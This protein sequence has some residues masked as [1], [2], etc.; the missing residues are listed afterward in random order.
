[1]LIGLSADTIQF[2]IIKVFRM[3]DQAHLVDLELICIDAVFK[4]P[5]N[6]FY[7]LLKGKRLFSRSNSH[8]I[9]E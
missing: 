3:N 2:K 8:L 4:Q 5:R 1:M 6:S 9:E 7:R